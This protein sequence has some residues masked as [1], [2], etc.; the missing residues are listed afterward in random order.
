MKVY[1]NCQKFKIGKV[2]YKLATSVNILCFRKT[3][4]K[5]QSKIVIEQLVANH[6]RDDG[7]C[8]YLDDDKKTDSSAD[9]CWL[10]VHACH[11]IHNGLCHCHNHGKHCQMKKHLNYKS[12]PT[13]GST[14]NAYLF[15]KTK[16]RHLMLVLVL[17]FLGSVEE[18]TV[19]R[20]VTYFNDFG[21]GQKLHDETGC[22]NG[23][24][25]QLHQSS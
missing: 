17:T 22:N 8:A 13:N 7:R 11:D 12:V 23:R 1:T 2:I 3:Q 10:A 24:D 5:T 21:T 16:D 4:S 15:H 20:G 14:I 25:S 19:L 18:G 9:F 6:N